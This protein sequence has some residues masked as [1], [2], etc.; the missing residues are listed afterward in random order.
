ML[1]NVGNSG[2]ELGVEGAEETEETEDVGVEGAESCLQ[3]V[4]HD[5]GCG[6][7]ST[8][9]FCCGE[10]MTSSGRTNSS[11]T[12]GNNFSTSTLTMSIWTSIGCSF[13]SGLALLTSSVV[14]GATVGTGGILTAGEARRLECCEVV[15]RIDGAFRL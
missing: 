11:L 7:S 1:V 8:L 3:T 6:C 15:E 9:E 10:E 12:V 13:S 2:E 5:C 4:T 14:K